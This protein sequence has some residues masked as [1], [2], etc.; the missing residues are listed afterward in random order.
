MSFIF[1]SIIG[2]LAVTTIFLATYTFRYYYPI[3]GKL[4]IAHRTLL[5]SLTGDVP[6]F[7]LSS[8]GGSDSTIGFGG[9]RFMRGFQSNRFLDKIRLVGGLEL[10]WDPIEFMFAGQDIKLG[11]VPFFDIGRVWPTVFPIRLGTWHAS[12]GWGA[13]IIWNSRIHHQRRFRSDR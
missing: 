4:V 13:R 2:R 7:E 11:F 6:Y 8:V 3:N 12:T 1:H 10:R 9:D 5:E